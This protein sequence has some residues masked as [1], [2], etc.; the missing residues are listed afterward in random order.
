MTLELLAVGLFALGFGVLGAATVVASWLTETGTC[1]TCG[2][3]ISEYEVVA[4]GR[5]DEGERERWYCS[6]DCA[7]LEDDTLEG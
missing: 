2:A 5:P 1:E 7:S 3:E 4:R 6:S